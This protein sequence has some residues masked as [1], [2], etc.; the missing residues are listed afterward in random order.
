MGVQSFEPNLGGH[1]RAGTDQA[2]LGCVTEPAVAAE[3]Q[4][5]AEPMG[6]RRKGPP[7]T[8]TD[9]SRLVPSPAPI[10]ERRGERPPHHVGVARQ[11]LLGGDDPQL[12]GQSPMLH[13][14]T[15]GLD[16]DRRGRP[17]AGGSRYRWTMTDTDARPQSPAPEGSDPGRQT[18]TTLRPGRRE[19][20]RLATRVAVSAAGR[21]AMEVRSPL[22][23]ELLGGVPVGTDADVTAA[24]ERARVVQRAWAAKPVKDRAAVLLRYHDLVLDRQDELLDLIQ[25]ENGKARV[26]AFEEIL[27]QAVTARYYARL[28]PRALKPK[29]KLTALPGLVR[30][31]EHHVPKGVIGVISP[32]N[33]P[34]VLAVS[35]ALAALVA[36]NAIVIKPDSQTPFT[37]IRAFELL[38]E[39]GVPAGLVQI[40]TGPGRSVGTAIIDQADYVMFTGSTDTGR[41]V[42]SQAAE[43]LI[44]MSAELG[45]KNPM[46]VTADVE[47]DTAV[48]G[49]VV[50]SFANTGQ[51]CISIERIYVEDAIADRFITAFGSRA[52]ALKLGAEQ[53][54]GAE[55]G[56]L[57]SQDQLDKVSAH[58][59]DAVAKGAR[60]VAGGKPR[61]DIGPYHYEPTVL[62]DVTPDMDVYARG[63]VRARRGRVPGHVDRRS[64][65]QGQRHRLRPQRQR[66]HGRR[67]AGPRHRR[68]AAGGDGQRERRVLLG[69]GHPRR[70]HGWH[71]GLRRRPPPRTRR[72]AQ[73][74]REPDHRCALGAGGQAP[75]PHRRRRRLRQPVHQD[76]QAGKAPAALGGRGRPVPLLHDHPAA[77]QVVVAVLGSDGGQAIDVA[78]EH[79]ERCGDQHGVVDLH[80]SRPGPTGAVDIAGGDAAAALLHLSAHLEQS[81]E[82]SRSPEQPRRREPSHRRHP[83][84]PRAAVPR[85]CRARC[86]R[87]GSR[88]ASRRRRQ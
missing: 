73:V 50:A 67:Q 87:S 83:T 49:A 77:L 30:T 75:R 20:D 19:T 11:V 48:E 28:A 38:E 2:R 8:I 37:A 3:Q 27:D 35:D 1:H 81:C 26:W 44:G 60:V 12:L 57:A 33:Y 62:A 55:V 78:V 5:I 13:P 21:E 74:H 9:A 58:V 52:A 39:A 84:H 68:P 29:T 24:M 51:L 18:G 76:P 71:E 56:A 40:V 46:V 63:D 53:S 34:L 70:A 31:W 72:P 88:S 45:G 15:L 61:P 14:P 41:K 43:R 36:G 32:W 64:R 65:R 42:A 6:H 66:V 54:Y 17:T 59:S 79:A 69:L 82:A 23:G 10:G 47:L 85:R 80:V 86:G 25:A 16:P 22:N 7:S 4:S